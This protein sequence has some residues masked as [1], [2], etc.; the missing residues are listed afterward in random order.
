[1][2]K[3]RRYTSKKG[4]KYELVQVSEGKPR[5]KRSTG[6]KAS[7]AKAGASTPKA[8]PVKRKAKRSSSGKKVRRKVAMASRM[9][10]ARA[11][12]GKRGNQKKKGQLLLIV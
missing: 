9:K 2:E 1:M 7:T 5:K 10:K 4:A 12:T 8:G 3:V 6:S 11:R